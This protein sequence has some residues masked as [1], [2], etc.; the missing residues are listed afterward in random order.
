MIKF[1]DLSLI[2]TIV[3]NV[4]EAGYESPTPIQAQS[5][6]PLIEGKD[7]LGIAQTGTGKTAAFTLP[8]LQKLAG[9]NYSLTPN[10]PRSLILAPTRE[11]ASQIKEQIDKYGKDLKLKS[12]VI[13]GGVGQANQVNALR[14]GLD[15]LIATPGRLI[16]LINQGY[17]KLNRIEI[18][19]L[20]EA[21]RMLDMGFIHDIKKIISLLPEKK[22]TMLFSATMPNEIVGIA[23]RILKNPVRVE[24]TPVSST[25]ERINQKV[26]FCQKAH[27]YQLLRKILMEDG[28][29]L[30]LVFTRTKHGA[31]KIVDYLSHHQIKS[32]AIHGN[33][34]QSA[35]E[36]A[37]ENFKKG[38]IK[39]LI[40]TDIAARGIDVQGVSHVINYDMPVD[41]ESY[42]HRIGRTARAGRDGD[43]ISF[44]DETERDALTRVQKLISLKLPVET[45][46]GVPEKSVKETRPS[47]PY[48][49]PRSKKPES[50]IKDKKTK[51]GYKFRDKK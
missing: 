42:V 30:S 41:A 45:F 10:E 15:I 32:V 21:D 8:M 23:N 40:A 3:K 22:Q 2:E 24:V 14:N 50:S 7:L 26:I 35:R 25:V 33:K 46:V 27:K 12:T 17:C 36:S 5:I 34:S 11:L 6:P 37:L 19:V 29:E 43:A 18:F 20:D 31:N 13:F 9:R 51:V 28:V 39:V 16:D 44:C 48:R 4:H 49:D 47:K 38:T 1:N